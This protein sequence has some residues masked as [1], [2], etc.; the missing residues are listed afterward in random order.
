VLAT[1]S[2]VTE[3]VG[4]IAAGGFERVGENREAVEGAVGVDGFG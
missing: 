2:A 4:V 1:L 3:D